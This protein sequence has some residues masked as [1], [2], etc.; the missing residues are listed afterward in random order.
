MT[1]IYNNEVK[2]I[3]ECNLLHEIIN[4]P[5]R[6]KKL[7]IHYSRIIHVCMNTKKGRAKFKNFRIILDSGCSSTVV[8][9]MIVK[10]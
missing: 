8:M 5:K 6:A 10:K 7:T 2:N 3:S 9:G 4:P 1:R